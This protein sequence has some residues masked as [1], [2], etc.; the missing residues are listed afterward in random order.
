MVYCWT[1]VCGV[2]SAASHSEVTNCDDAESPVAGEYPNVVQCWV[3]LEKP[4]AAVD[5]EN[6]AGVPLVIVAVD[7]MMTD[8]SLFLFIPISDGVK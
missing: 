3:V 4:D 6:R 8:D 1:V 2:E 5:A 7:L